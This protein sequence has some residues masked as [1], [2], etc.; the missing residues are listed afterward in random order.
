MRQSNQE[1]EWGGIW[2]NSWR[3]PLNSKDHFPQLLQAVHSKA[4]VTGLTHGFYRY[5]ARFSP[6]LARAVI[7]AFTEPGDCVIDPFMGGGTTAVEALALDRKCVGADVSS[8][9]VFLTRTKCT[10]LSGRSVDRIRDWSQVH[11]SDLNLSRS[12]DSSGTWGAYQKNIPWWIRKTLSLILDL[13]EQLHYQREQDFVRCAL[14]KTGQWALDCRK[15]IPGSALFIARLRKDIDEMISGAIAYRQ[16]LLANTRISPSQLSRN[17]RL[18]SCSAADIHKQGRIP[19]SWLPAKLVLTSPPYPGVHILYHRWQVRG[20]RETAAPFWIADCMDG[21]GASYYTFGDRKRK[22]LAHYL[23]C[24][25]EA[26][27]SIL[28]LLNQ[29]SVIVQLV[30]FA[31]PQKQLP[32][33]LEAMRRL[34][35]RETSLASSRNVGRIWRTV[36]NRKWY[37]DCRQEKPVGEV[38]LCHRMAP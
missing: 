38:V 26:W 14:L 35:L 18:L 30:G 21:R 22:S 2:A 12:T 3:R 24:L 29:E 37:V 5:P 25:E 23:K 31:D 11:L 34:G 1:E 33:Y 20:R 16:R 8:L 10:P 17:R 9:A 6:Q 19:A 32:Q 15:E 28:R 7:E 4:P 27:D 13:A 36:P